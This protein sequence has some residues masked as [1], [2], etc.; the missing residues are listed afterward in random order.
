MIQTYENQFVY[1]VLRE[2]IDFQ[3]TRNLSRTKVSEGRG[4]VENQPAIVSIK[5]IKTVSHTL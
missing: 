2:Q 4:N 5:E 1:P 3:H